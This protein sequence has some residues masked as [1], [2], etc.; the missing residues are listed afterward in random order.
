M[1]NGKKYFAL[2]ERKRETDLYIF[3]RVYKTKEKISNERVKG[4]ET[5]FVFEKFYRSSKM[6]KIWSFDR[7]G[8]HL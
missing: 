6:T 8:R 4:T 2:T 1:K 7:V 3:W 5:K